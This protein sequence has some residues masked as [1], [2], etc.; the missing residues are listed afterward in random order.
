MIPQRLILKNFLCYREDVPALDFT[1]IHL[2][3]L[4]GPNGHGKSALLDAITWCLWGR[5]RGKTHDDL[6][7]YGADECHVELEF[8]SRDTQ[9]RAVRAHARGGG[10]GRRRQGVTDLQLQVLSNGESQPITGNQIRET[11][12]KIDQIVG[13]DYDTFI[14]SAFLLQGRADEF[15]NK[16]PA[17][18][19]AVLAKILG[20]ETYDRL[21]ARARER[22]EESRAAS[23]EVDGALGQMRRQVEEIGDPSEELAGVELRMQ[24]VDPQLEERRRE[25]EEL[26]RAVAELERKRA[27]LDELQRQMEGIRQEAVHLESAVEAGRAR[28]HQ[29]QAL[30]QQADSVQQGAGRLD[31]ARC[32]FEAL[33]EARQAFGKLTQDK[34]GLMRAIDGA[35]ARLEAQG[36]QLRR[37]VEVELP[38]KAGAEADLAKE[39]DETRRR[40]P[41]LEA[42]QQSLLFHRDNQQTLATRIGE[43]KS[44]AERYEVEGQELR[45]KLELLQRNGHQEA[46]CPL[47]QSP[48]GEDGCGRLSETYR[49]DIEEKRGLYRR[50]A[51]KLRELEA[52]RAALD[53]DLPRRERALAQAQREAGVKTNDLKRAIQESRAAQNE[54]DQAKIQLSDTMASLAS[55]KFAAAEQGQLG[56]LNFRIQAL[57]YDEEARRQ[58]YSQIQ[59]LEPFAEKLRQLS[60]AETSLP[61]EQ[62]SVAR[63]EEMLQRRKSEVERLQERHR[64]DEAAAAALPKLEARRKEAEAAQR[65]LEGQRQHAIDRRGYLRGQ[66]ERLEGLQRD[67][68]GKSDRLSGLQEDQGIYQEL[69]TAFGRQGVQAM[70]IETVVPRLEDEANGLLGRMT[71]N[72]MQVKLETQRERR[73]G[74]GDPIE[75]LEIHVSDEL[76]PRSYEM[77]SGGEAFRVNLA[78]RIALSKVL[79]Q[80]M[81][82]PMPTLFIDEG[83]GTQDAAGRERVLDV[84]AAIQDDFE[85]IIVITHLEDLKDVFPVRIEVQKEESG[86]TFWLS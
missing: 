61:Q 74:R 67:M 16:T 21:Q 39:L 26:G 62:A 79:A 44:V 41:A 7:S 66:V 43:A 36:E 53:R 15:S 28:V 68:A 54:L 45:A 72:R 80:R 37:R 71:D 50:N 18:R 38:P 32:R 27:Q 35:R 1:G 86:S 10:G 55:G 82:A 81:G 20:L 31:E 75:T 34:Q 2:A 29:Y 14:N 85:K 24:Q 3:C 73:T 33:E 63:T 22:L 83:F 57:G 25:A 65:E 69:V 76:G 60:D 23:A 5:A 64:T 6:I 46:V 78:L 42:E 11:Q 8:Q 17:D 59:Q 70:L 52:E 13:M 77:Y 47:C 40:Q 19:K 30:L 56:E 4:C 12:A 51:S 48:L 49:A 58:T 84:I 9:Y